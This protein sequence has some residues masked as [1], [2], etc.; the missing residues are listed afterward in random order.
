MIRVL[1]QSRSL[2]LHQMGGIAAQPLFHRFGTSDKEQMRLLDEEKFKS[3]QI[4][5]NRPDTFRFWYKNYR[6]YTKIELSFLNTSVALL[7]YLLVPGT[8]LFAYKTLFFA[9]ATQT[10]A[11]SSQVRNQ[12]IEVREDGLMERTSKRPFVTGYFRGYH[13]YLGLFTVSNA[14]FLLCCPFPAFVIGNL[15]KFSYLNIYTPAKKTSEAN[16]LYGAL[17]GAL[18]PFLGVAGAGGSLLALTP[19][20]MCLFVFSWQYPHFYGILWTYKSGYEKAGF[21][22]IS[23]SDKA[24][25]HMYLAMVGQAI[26]IAL[27]Y[28][29]GNYPL[30]GAVA[31]VGSILTIQYSAV[32]AFKVSQDRGNAKKLKRAAYI[33]FLLFFFSLVSA[34]YS[35]SGSKVETSEDGVPLGTQHKPPA[36][37]TLSVALK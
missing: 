29:E 25:R 36:K 12:M 10:L 30:L 19:W 15:I 6:E 24:C 22:M 14:L 28:Y 7:G 5:R 21:K 20:A 34:V 4:T 1:S 9:I 18:T 16:T 3:R 23:D 32:R 17:I 26:S 13:H 37:D 2:F 31:T 33:P 8:Q 27:L 11:M 35:K